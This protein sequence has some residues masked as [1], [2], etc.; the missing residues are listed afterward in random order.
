[1]ASADG[2]IVIKAEVDAR[3]A[4]KELNKLENKIK[5]TEDT[6]SDL[7]KKRKEADETS[8][9]KANELD[10]EKAK[11]K[12]IK[13][14]LAEIKQLSSDKSIPLFQR[15]EYKAQLPTMKD[16]YAE[17][18]ERVRALQSEYNKVA[19]S[20]SRYD[21]KLKDANAALDK[22]KARA[23]ELVKEITA[24]GSASV[25]MAEA[26]ARVE[27][28]AQRF[29]ERLSELVG[30]ALIF[31]TISKGLSVVREWMGKV[32]V[33]NDEARAAFAQL[34]GALLTLAQPL[35]EVVIPALITFVNILTQVIS[36]IAQLIS[37][38]FGKS[39]SQS[40]AAAKGL[41]SE[42]A[43]IGSVGAAAEEA[44][45]SLAA[46]DEINTISTENASGGGGGGGGAGEIEPNFDFES[47]LLGEDQL[48]NLLGIIQAI[49]SALLAWKIGSALGLGLKE[50]LGLAV[51]I[52]SA[53]EFV[54]NMFDAWVNGVSWGNLLGMLLSAAG[55]AAGLYVAF[56]AAAAGIGLIISGIAMLATGFHDA[57]VNGW[58]LQNLLLSIAGIMA[59]GIGIA[60]L[61][62]SWIPLLIAGIASLLLAFAVATGH[63]EELLAGVRQAME[64]FIDFFVGVFTGDIQRAIDGVGKIFEGLRVIVGAVVDGIRDT[65]LIFF[66][67]LDEK[68]NGKFH[69]IIEAAK[70]IITVFFDSVK[71]ILQNAVTVIEQFFTGIIQ[72][73]L[74]VFTHD[75]DM[76]WQGLKNIVSSTIGTIKD[77][78]LEAVKFITGLLDGIGNA[79][80][81]VMNSLSSL[82]SKGSAVSKTVKAD[83]GSLV[84]RSASDF[85]LT[86]ES[87]GAPA[88]MPTIAGRSIPALAAGAVIPPNREFLAVLGDQRSG[89]NIEAPADL[90]RQIV[91][92]EAGGSMELL[93]VL[94]MILEAVR[95]GKVIAV[96]GTVFGRTAIRTI[97]SVNTAAG[98]QML[99]I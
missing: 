89:T 15:N 96:D 19:N 4:Q 30:S 13:D 50:I 91:R 45:G 83:V 95:E 47:A 60:L 37:F 79:I 56:G 35:M 29:G 92:E 18:R 97:N 5:Q 72:F 75:W 17:Q 90:I 68:T 44:A 58:N 71:T 57:F 1:M 25:K 78:F 65:F 42:A 38:L 39:F 20:V 27:K 6:I 74:G 82:G 94:Q 88:P 22:Q 2:S 23:G 48:K 66:D 34:Q 98:R 99:K 62:G 49:G 77:L 52:Y 61:T 64:G 31:T 46:F 67:W 87:Q 14:R 86:I 9:F 3:D 84:S 51:A 12:E 81:G 36:V 69:G 54:K 26:Q 21:E 10:A 32:I 85:T 28:S 80:K 41:N 59:A 16:E 24:A 93:S 53:I 63:G 76:V 55:I 73:F 8:A 43:A 7:Q 11:L 33:T 40:K 70:G